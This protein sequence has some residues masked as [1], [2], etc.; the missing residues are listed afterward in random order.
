MKMQ[1]ILLTTLLLSISLSTY[2]DER[3]FTYTY[4]STVLGRGVKELEVWSTVRVGKNIPYFARLDHRIEFEWG[5]TNRLQTAFYLNFRN[6]SR[7]DSAGM[8]SAFNFQGISSEWKYQFTRPSKDPIGFAL[9]GEIG[10]NT[11]KIELESKLIFDKRLGR[12]TFALNLVLENEWQLAS[13]KPETE[14]SL[15]GDFGWSYNITNSFA[16][17]I[18]VRNHNEIVQ[19]EWEH[20][21]LFAGPVFSYSQPAWWATLTVLPQITAFKGNT[22]SSNLVLDEHEK[23]ETRLIFSFRM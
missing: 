1:K 4:Q 2:A 13:H 14:L 12:N 17:G 10:L 18:E 22:G 7:D 9:Y 5:I 3:K 11:Q 20:S 8:N 15:E 16:A 23:L 21:A 6:I 19:G